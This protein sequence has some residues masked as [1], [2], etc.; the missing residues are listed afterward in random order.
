MEEAKKQKQAKIINIVVNVIV[1]IILV[2]ALVVTINNLASSKKG[3]TSLFGNAFMVCQTDSM[4]GDK[5]EKYADKP[6][7]FAP[8]D[9]LRVKILD[10]DEKKNLEEGDIISFYALKD[11]E[12]IINSHRIV[13]VL[14]EDDGN[15]RYTTKG[16][17]PK[18]TTD[19][20]V[21]AVGDDQYYVVIGVVESN[22]GGI[23][24][25][26]NFFQSSTGF[27]VCVVV[28]SFL[29][30]LYFAF[31]L[32]R[33]IMKT[34]KV[35]T[36]DEKEQ[37]K[38]EIMAELRAQGALT[39]PPA[40]SDKNGGEPPTDGPAESDKDGEDPAEKENKSE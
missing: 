25:V 28:P 26:F 20:Y 6:D 7:G 9:L 17:N 29:V 36:A 22:L 2:L 39:E 31:N 16:D 24:K 8:G 21:Y 13:G 23:G 34:K 3:Y 32:F 14:Q 33:E 30:V 35:S 4:V 19:P 15:V 38:A 11:R 12:R 5:D 1:A 27:L 10:D 18:A 40:E 37:M